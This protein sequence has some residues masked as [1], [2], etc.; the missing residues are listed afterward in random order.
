MIGWIA[1]FVDGEGCFSIG[2][3]KQPDR[4]EKTRMRRGYKLGYQAFPEFSVTQGAKSLDSLKIL[5]KFFGVGKIYHNKRYDNHKEHLYR[6]VIR[7]R[8]DIKNIIIP[9]FRKYPMR[10][11]KQND[12]EKFARCVKMID[13]G[14]HLKKKGFI[15][16]A[17]IVSTMNRKKS[18]QSIINILRDQTSISR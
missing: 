7:K 13:N 2:I 10:T 11:A 9:F 4:Q 15:K 18:R 3:Y 14:E 16:I 8:K 6:F 1:G 17:Q 12:F 5:Q